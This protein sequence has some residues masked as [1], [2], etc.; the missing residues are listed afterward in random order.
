MLSTPLMLGS[1]WAFVPALLAVIGFVIRTA[2]E[3]RTLQAELPGYADY[4]ARV[5]FRLV[6]GV[7]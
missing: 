6:P 7:W 1:T 2:L 3:D 5:R 4:A